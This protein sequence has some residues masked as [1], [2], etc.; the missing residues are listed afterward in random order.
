MRA[1][2]ATAAGGLSKKIVL[3][4][5]WAIFGLGVLI[6]LVLSRNAWAEQ[7]GSETAQKPELCE[8][9]AAFDEALQLRF[10]RANFAPDRFGC[11]YYASEGCSYSVAGDFRIRVTHVAPLGCEGGECSFMARQVCETD[12]P[13]AACAAIMFGP[14]SE[15]RVRGR[16][17]A[18]KNGAWRLTDWVREH[19]P[20]LELERSRIETMCP[21]LAKTI[22]G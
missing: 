22:P 5:F 18:L 14:H 6:A 15:Y 2:T 4:L 16:F 1:R 19:G 7:S 12:Q 17:D 3:H 11:H 8:M 13:S 10:Y 9:V 21:E 20:E